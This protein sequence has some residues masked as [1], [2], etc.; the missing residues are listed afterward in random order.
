MSKVDYSKCI[1]RADAL[2]DVYYNANKDT[3]STMSTLERIYD[4]YEIEDTCYSVKDIKKFLDSMK[5]ALINVGITDPDGP[6]SSVFHLWQY[7]YRDVDE[8]KTYV[9]LLNKIEEK[10][11]EKVGGSAKKNATPRRSTRRRKSRTASTRRRRRANRRRR[12]ARK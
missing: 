1:A 5:S 7:V 8:N 10:H 4:N 12:T 11:Y 3:L 9:D 2:Y 6:Y